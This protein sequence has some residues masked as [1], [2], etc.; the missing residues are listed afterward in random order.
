VIDRP[1]AAGIHR[2]ALPTPF[3][4]GRVNCWLVDDVPLTLVDC[5]PNSGETLEALERALAELG[6]RVEDLERIVL[7]HQHV[8]HVGLAGVLARRSGAEVCAIAGLAPRLADFP[9]TAEAEDRFAEE[10]MRRHGVDG[11]VVT[12]VRAVTRTFRG[13]GASVYV[14][15]PLHDGD[16][17]P[18]TSRTWEVRLAPGHSPSDTVFWDARNHVLVAGDHLLGHV[19]SSPLLQRPLDYAEGD[20]RPRALLAYIASLRA[21]RELGPALVLPGHGE[22]FTNH[23]EIIDERFE[24]YERRARRIY[25]VLTGGPRTAHEIARGLWRDTAVALAFLMTSEVLGHLDL[26]LVHGAAAER[27][28]G[29]VVRFHALA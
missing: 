1:Q 15:R 23:V 17:L 27:D 26:L 16:T 14:D 8:D 21:T 29:D 13:W 3:A 19:T 22:P 10:S 28:E 6:R 2:I 4:I 24:A 25:A 5:G 20:P 18:F 7:T 11:D 9:A 12:A